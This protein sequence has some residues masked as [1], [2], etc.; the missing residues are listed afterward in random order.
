MNK[1]FKGMTS[2]LVL[3][4]LFLTMLVPSVLAASLT[5]F[6]M[7]T[8]GR[9]FE[10][11]SL[12]Y[13]LGK[14]STQYYGIA[15]QFNNA[16]SAG[17]SV[18]YFKFS[19]NDGGI[20]KTVYVSPGTFTYYLN[21]TKSSTIDE[22]IAKCKAAQTFTPMTKIAKFYSNAGVTSTVLE[23]PQILSQ[24]SSISIGRY[25]DSTAWKAEE[26]AANTNNPVGQLKFAFSKN[27]NKSSLDNI[28]IYLNGSSSVPDCEALIKAIIFGEF[29]DRS[30]PGTLSNELSCDFFMTYSQLKNAL[31]VCN[32]DVA[33]TQLKIE[34]LATDNTWV[35]MTIDIL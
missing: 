29:I 25:P 5:S 6:S 7:N 13:S 27:L 21:P 15:E 12:T 4:L 33:V 22:A 24:N 28:H 18:Q 9:E 23:G 17:E 30:L 14:P 2:L 32:D 10:V 1:T 35:S 8:S 26:N 19:Y 20:T 11:T 34:G 3:S 31:T 16:V